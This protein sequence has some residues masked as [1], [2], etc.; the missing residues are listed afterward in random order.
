[1]LPNMNKKRKGDEN[2]LHEDMEK[3]PPPGSN[4]YVP[5]LV[6]TKRPVPPMRARTC[7]FAPVY[8]SPSPSC[9][10]PPHPRIPDPDHP[11]LLSQSAYESIDPFPVCAG[12]EPLGTAL[13]SLI[14]VP[15][16]VVSRLNLFGLPLKPVRAA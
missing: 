16:L 15:G 11:P 8:S 10:S 2:A 9:T 5:K 3:R 13:C 14:A 6:P 1:M 12:L 4:K 7:T